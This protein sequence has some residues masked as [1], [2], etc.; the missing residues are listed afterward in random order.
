MRSLCQELPSPSSILLHRDVK[1]LSYLYHIIQSFKTNKR[2]GVRF[3]YNCYVFYALYKG[4]HFLE[5]MVNKFQTYGSVSACILDKIRRTKGAAKGKNIIIIYVFFP[6]F[7][8]LF[9]VSYNDVQS[10]R[11]KIIT[12]FGTNGI[13]FIRSC[14]LHLCCMLVSTHILLF[15]VVLKSSMCVRK[16]ML[17]C[18]FCITHYKKWSAG[19]QSSKIFGMNWTVEINVW[20][21]LQQNIILCM[22]LC[23]EHI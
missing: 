5:L 8:L 17:C 19:M 7:S 10:M 9:V 20:N 11:W 4:T 21:Y 23:V 22:L 12:T 3:V 2:K 18:V 15:N 6:S 13:L 14:M 1:S 16:F